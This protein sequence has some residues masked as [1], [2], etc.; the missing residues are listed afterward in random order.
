MKEDEFWKRLFAVRQCNEEGTQ[1]A[2]CIGNHRAVEQF[3]ATREEA[4]DYAKV[5]S[6]EL[7]CAVSICLYDLAV[8]KQ[9]LNRLNNKEEEKE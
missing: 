6:W 2:I 1:W 5:P 7:I 8:A 3:F 4:E 9:E